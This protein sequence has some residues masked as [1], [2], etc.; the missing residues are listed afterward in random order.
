LAESFKGLKMAIKRKEKSVAI[1]KLSAK[2][3][4]EQFEQVA[5]IIRANISSAHA[6]VNAIVVE[7]YWRVG[8]YISGKVDGA[9][10]GEGVVENLAE[11]LA[12]TLP[13]PRGFSQRNLWRM[14]Q[15]YETYQRD[16]K[17]STLLT[18]LPWSSHLH[19]MSKSRTP[20]EREFYLR[21]SIKEKYDVRTVERAI[22]NGMFERAVAARPKLS[23]VLREVHPESKSI[24]RDSYSLDFLGLKDGHSEFDLRKAIVRSLKEFIIEF[25]RDFAF[26]GEEYRVQVGMKDFFLDLLFYHRELRCLV[27]FELKIDEFKPEYLG[28]LSFYLEA[29]DRDVKKQHENPSIGI[30]LC[31]GKDDE[32]V[33][34]ALSRTLSPAAIA[35]YTTR[36][37]DKR[38]LQDKLHEFFDSSVRELQPEY[39]GKR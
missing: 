30:I 9:G 3:L 14:K 34:Y 32:V 23:A 27:A 6:A 1:K 20:E 26:V 2:N 28:K 25:G 31:K 36:L 39:E 12:H 13:N 5:A 18:E 22:E 33:E 24:I 11:F 16:R 35:D 17:L 19:I 8:E 38:L 37:P 21:L 4:R 15:F 29:L 10:W 7:T